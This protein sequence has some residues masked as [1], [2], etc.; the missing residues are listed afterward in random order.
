[1]RCRERSAS[2]KEETSG[3]RN[4]PIQDPTS[5]WAYSNGNLWPV[6]TTATRPARFVLYRVLFA[7][8]LLLC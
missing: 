8:R 4:Q 3:M 2:Q 7:L 1:M 5:D 6:Q